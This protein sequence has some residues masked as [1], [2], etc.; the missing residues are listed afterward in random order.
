MCLSTEKGKRSPTKPKLT[1]KRKHSPVDISDDDKVV[2]ISQKKAKEA[3]AGDMTNV[4]RI[5]S[6][7]NPE[8]CTLLS[9]AFA[10]L[11]HR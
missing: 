4:T 8:T 7:L 9:L 5:L 1:R 11:A 6:S 3:P 2:T 10:E